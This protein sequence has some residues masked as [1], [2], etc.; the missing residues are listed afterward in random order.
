MSVVVP[1]GCLCGGRLL[2][3]PICFCMAGSVNVAA[4]FSYLLVTDV[5]ARHDAPFCEA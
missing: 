1:F 2:L 3:N 5:S 4:R